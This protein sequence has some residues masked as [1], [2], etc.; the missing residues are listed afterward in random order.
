MFVFFILF[1]LVIVLSCKFCIVKINIVDEIV[2][3]M[4]LCLMKKWLVVIFKDDVFLW[5]VINLKMNYCKVYFFCNFVF[6]N[7]CVFF[8]FL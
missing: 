4:V 8:V 2:L 5:E 6:M 1:C 3:F 7:N